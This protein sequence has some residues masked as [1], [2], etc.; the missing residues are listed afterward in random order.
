MTLRRAISV[1][2]PYTTLFRSRGLEPVHE[3]A[4]GLGV[5]VVDE[6]ELRAFDLERRGARQN[7][8]LNDRDEDDL[9]K[10]QPIAHRSVEHTSELQS[11]VHLVCRLLL[12]SKKIVS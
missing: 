10:H 9:T 8:E 7:Q 3:S 1:L 11:P 4:R 5:I 12:E 2:F 6:V